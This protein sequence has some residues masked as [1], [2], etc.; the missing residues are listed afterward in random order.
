LSTRMPSRSPDPARTATATTR[1]WALMSSP[2]T[3][4]ITGAAGGL[5][6]AFA[7]GFAAKGDRIAVADINLE[8]AQETVDKLTADGATTAQAS[9][10][11]V[12]SAE[13]TT[14]LAQQ[15]AEFG[16]G[17]IDVLVNNAAIYATVTRSPFEDI[18]PD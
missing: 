15:V 2:R 13:S 18:D 16:G 7:E 14:K 17:S 11:D 12:T 4:L 6:R 8:G 1:K 9:A 3:V 5:G 10:V